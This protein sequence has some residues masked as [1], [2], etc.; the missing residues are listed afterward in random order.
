MTEEEKEKHAIKKI[1]LK[2]SGFTVLTTGLILIII[3]IIDFFGAF[4]GDDM[5]KMFWMLIIGIPLS[6]IGVALLMM[7]FRKEI[8]TY[9]K[10]ES[11]STYNEFGEEISPA[12]RSISK[13][14]NEGN[15]KD[16]E[17]IMCSCGEEN[18]AEDKFCK[19]C[20]RELY[21]ICSKC[22]EQVELDCN[23]CPKCGQKIE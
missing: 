16:Q 2:V 21:K 3:G 11:V 20:G 23:Y 8:L 13:A 7:G 15:K 12:I 4:N 6:A 22:G 18:K 10:N 17:S 14:A 9:V 1:I 5:P 19:N